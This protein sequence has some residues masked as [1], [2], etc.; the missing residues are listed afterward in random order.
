MEGFGQ[1]TTFHLEL[2]KQTWAVFHRRAGR[3]GRDGDRVLSGARASPPSHWTGAG[4]VLHF[5]APALVGA[6]WEGKVWGQEQGE[7]ASPP[8][9]QRQLLKCLLA[10]DREGFEHCTEG[11][12]TAFCLSAGSSPFSCPSIHSIPSFLP[13][14]VF[15]LEGMRLSHGATPRVLLPCC[16]HRW[17]Q[18]KSGQAEMRQVLQERT[19]CGRARI[20]H[21]CPC[22]AET[23][24]KG[25]VIC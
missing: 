12:I 24:G 4:M 8:P 25:K 6:G 15:I 3:M 2:T 1:H 10:S 13:T 14:C 23:G 18:Q 5:L 11:L 9:E 22:L 16:K 19:R 20:H 7:G 17:Q 21:A